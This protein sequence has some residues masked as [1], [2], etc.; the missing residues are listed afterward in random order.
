MNAAN[1]SQGKRKEPPIMPI[2]PKGPPQITADDINVILD[3]KL[4]KMFTIIATNQSNMEKIFSKALEEQRREFKSAQLVL[5]APSCHAGL[6]Y[7][8]SGGL[9]FSPSTSLAGIIMPTNFSMYF[10]Y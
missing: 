4:E 5:S 1:I 3:A 7:S 9:N 8:P 10:I 6:N 2:P